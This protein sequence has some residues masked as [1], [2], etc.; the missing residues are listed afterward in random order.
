MEQHAGWTIVG[1]KDTCPFC[2]EKVSLKQ[3]HKQRP[4][5]SSNVRWNGM[6]NDDERQR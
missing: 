3:L 6:Q 4:W 5:E 2:K 1:G